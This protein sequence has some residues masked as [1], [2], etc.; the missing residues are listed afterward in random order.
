MTRMLLIHCL[1]SLLNLAYLVFFFYLMLLFI[2]LN[3]QIPI[4]NKIFLMSFIVTQTI[5][6]AGYFNGAFLFIIFLLFMAHFKKSE[7][8]N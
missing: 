4:D 6:G 8:L 5:R 3:N 7:I 2:F 1:K